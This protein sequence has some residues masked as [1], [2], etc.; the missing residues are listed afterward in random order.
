MKSCF[1]P[2]ADTHERETTRLKTHTRERHTRERHTHERETHTRETTRHKREIQ[3]H[4]A[5]A[6]KAN[7]EISIAIDMA[8]GG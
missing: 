5:W 4:S 8:G 6:S 1:V 3:R 7:L 2:R